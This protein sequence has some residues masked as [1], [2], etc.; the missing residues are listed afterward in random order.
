M[1]QR[2]GHLHH[3]RAHQSS[4]QDQQPQDQDDRVAAETGEGL[5][6]RQQAGQDQRQQHPQRDDVDRHPFEGEQDQR[7]NQDS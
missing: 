6:R 4:R 3:A 5:V 1:I 7:G 2:P